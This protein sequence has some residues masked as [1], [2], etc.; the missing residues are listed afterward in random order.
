MSVTTYYGRV[1]EEQ[2]ERMA[3]HPD[4]LS[5]FADGTVPKEQMLYLDKAAPVLAW[6][7]SPLKRHEQLH[8][9]AVVNA[10]DDIESFQKPDFGPEPAF[11]ELLVPIEGRGETREERLDMGMGPACVIVPADVKRFS[12][13]LSSID[14]DR[15]REQLDYKA[16][17]EAALPVDYWQEE[18]DQTF[19]EYILPLFKQLQAFYRDAAS[20]DQHVLVWYN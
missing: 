14:E 13:H 1:T 7:L 12:D 16:M 8:F 3:N 19:N 18:G 6:L 4:G 9:A 2:L 17:D 20:R 10:R 11:D 5:Q 15:L